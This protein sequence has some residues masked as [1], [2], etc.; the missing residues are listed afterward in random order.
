VKD[1]LTHFYYYND[2]QGCEQ[3]ILVCLAQRVNMREVARWSWTEGQE[4]G[5]A[6]FRRELNQRRRA[7]RRFVRH[8]TRHA[9]R[10]CDSG[11][12]FA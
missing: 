9:W 6:E 11:P 1:R 4:A 12:A 8:Q 3:A 7:P 2:R 5:F 10:L